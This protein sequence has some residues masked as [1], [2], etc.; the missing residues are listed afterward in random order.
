MSLLQKQIEWLDILTFFV[1]IK[2]QTSILKLTAAPAIVDVFV[3]I[4]HQTS[5]LKLTAAPAI[6]DFLL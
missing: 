1:A 5:I 6:V 3:A 2:P 4:K